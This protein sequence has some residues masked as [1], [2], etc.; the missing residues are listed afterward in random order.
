MFENC[1]QLIEIFYIE[2]IINSSNEENKEFENDYY[3]NFN[4]DYNNDDDGN[5][6]DINFV[7]ITILIM[8]K[9]SPLSKININKF[10][11]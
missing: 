5:D 8:E 9:K 3:L 4:K 1:A 10:K 2:N 6:T 7:T 11:K